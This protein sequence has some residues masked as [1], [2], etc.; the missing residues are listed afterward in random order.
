MATTKLIG[1]D[2]ATGTPDGADYILLTKFQAVAT[3]QV[4]EFRE[5]AGVAGQAKV[6]IYADNAGEPGARLSYNNTAQ[7][8]GAGWNTLSIPALDV[9]SGTYYW[10]GINVSVYNAIRFISGASANFRYKAGT[11][12]GFTW[13]DPAGTG[14]A[15]AAEIELVAGWG[16]QVVAPSGI[17]QGIAY[18][19]PIVSTSGQ[20]IQP[21]GIAQVIALGTPTVIKLLQI[22][23]PSG[24]EQPIALGTPALRYPQTISPSGIAQLVV[25][26]T[27]SVGA[28]GI[29]SPPGIAQVIAIGT[30]TSSQV[31][32]ACYPGRPV[33][34]RD[35]RDEPSLCYR[36]RH[37]RQPCLRHSR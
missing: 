7:N 18:G 5:K 1:A 8:V 19:T 20:V 11:F 10:L 27:P 6:A 31:C 16:V 32:L 30:P 21:S 25:F 4:T 14:Y 12:A 15:S 2:D 29:I 35:A 24:I 26:G 3:G 17:A 28:Y 36:Q 37:L 9:I 13:P 23:Y 33:L 34:H 22:I